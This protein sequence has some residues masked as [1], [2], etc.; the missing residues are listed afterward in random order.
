MGVT[1]GL[2]NGKVASPSAVKG[3]GKKPVGDGPKQMKTQ[4]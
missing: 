3:G 2:A 1:D 4:V